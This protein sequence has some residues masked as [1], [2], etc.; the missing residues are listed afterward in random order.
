LAA[1]V[2]NNDRIW[3]IKLHGAR[4]TVIAE[5]E[6]FKAFLNSMQFSDGSGVS[7]GDK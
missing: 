5:E 1:M 4:D 2:T 3:F 6:S 7:N